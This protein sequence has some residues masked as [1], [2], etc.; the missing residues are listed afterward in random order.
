MITI[1]KAST[2]AATVVVV[3]SM[4]LNACGDSDLVEIHDRELDDVIAALED[5]DLAPA[6]P[7][8]PQNG[9]DTGSEGEQTSDP[10][11]PL[12]L[13]LGQYE[14][15]FSEE[16]TGDS[17][18]E[19]KWNTA[20]SWGE[21]FFIYNQQQFYVDVLQR[22]DFGYNPFSFDG[23]ALTVTAIETPENLRAAAFEQPWLSGVLTTADRFDVSY[24]YIET[25]ISVE[26][27]VGLWPSFW[28]LSSAF[29]GLRPEV[30]VMEYDGSKPDSVFHNYN[31]L[32]ADD[33][34]VTPGQFEVIREGFSSGYHTVGVRWTE[35]DLLFYID[36]SPSYRIVGDN[37]PTEAMYLVLNLAV[38]GIWPGSPDATTPSA[39]SITIDYVRVYKPRS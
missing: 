20:L 36:G 5:T 16:F 9:V 31:Y 28:L 39:P 35:Q 3:L 34:Q 26:Q 23:D 18:D 11:N 4:F 38:G 24:G 2:S 25:R 8:S 6:N 21:E 12:A 15:I 30:Y 27:G 22:P 33:N 32:D 7:T 29:D 19:S 13:N 37:V 10:E 14:L 1:H 17:I